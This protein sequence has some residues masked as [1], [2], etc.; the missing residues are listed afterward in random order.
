M[1]SHFKVK[2]LNWTP[3]VLIVYHTGGGQGG[4]RARQAFLV[5]IKLHPGRQLPEW[6]GQYSKCPQNFDLGMSET[7]YISFTCVS[8]GSKMDHITKRETLSI[9]YGVSLSF[10]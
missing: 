9:G 2:W 6:E 7:I 8:T 4:G 3:V 5:F 10:V 1:K